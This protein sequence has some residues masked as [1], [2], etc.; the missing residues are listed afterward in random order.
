MLP[1]SP[2]APAYGA[3]E[4]CVH[5]PTGSSVVW[6]MPAREDVVRAVPEDVRHD[7][8]ADERGEDEPDDEEAADDR[9]LSRRKRIQ[10][11][12]Q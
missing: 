8:R 7:R 4:T 9:D 2:V 6:S 5:G 12:S 10:T 3:F 11:C 1:K